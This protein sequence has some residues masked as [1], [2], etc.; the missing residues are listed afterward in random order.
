MYKLTLLVLA[1]IILA[2]SAFQAPDF[3]N[4][5]ECPEFNSLMT[6]GTIEIREYPESHWVSTDMKGDNNSSGFMTLFKYIS[7]NNEAQEKMKM[8]APVLKKVTAKTPFTS[9]VTSTMSFYLGS[10]YQNGQAPKPTDANVYLQKIA[11]KKVAV[12]TYSGYSNKGTEEKNLVALGNFLTK[13]NMKFNN[14]FYFTAGY[15][16]PFKFL[17]RHNEVWVE[18]N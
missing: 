2:A 5:I 14:E 7:G 4:G 10:K 13:N 3:C 12:I 11:Y 17:F 6:E 18:L 16:S 1:S 8:T 9:D 15:D